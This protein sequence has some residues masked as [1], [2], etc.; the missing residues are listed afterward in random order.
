MFDRATLESVADWC[1]AHRIHLIVNEIYGLSR[2]DT[3]HPELVADYRSHPEF[4]SFAPILEQR[5]SEYLHCCYA[6][7]KDFGLSGFRIGMIYS[8]NDESIRAFGLLN[9]FSMTSNLT[10]W[11]MQ[12][13]LEDEEFVTSFIAGN[14]A[15]LT[16][17]YL[18]VVRMLRRCGIPYAPSRGS[19]FVWADLSEL[20]TADT[21]DAAHDL[22]QKIYDSTGVLLTPGEGF[23]HTK[24]GMLRIVY[25]SVD[26][27]SL[28][29]AMD[30]LERF[31]VQERS[32]GV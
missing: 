1:M 13:V 19:L 20:L 24:N 15:K 28:L 6:L 8:H 9:T 32:A 26:R 22:W 18:D 12:N 23:G 2:I 7:S 14:K 5:Q 27:D 10:Q 4:V 30:R 21:A 25:S 16:V 29:V 31:I 11:V 3:Q 17:A